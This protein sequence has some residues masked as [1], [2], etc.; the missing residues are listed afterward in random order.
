LN[1]ILIAF[2]GYGLKVIMGIVLN[3]ELARLFAEEL[4]VNELGFVYL[5]SAGVVFRVNGI[6]FVIDAGDLLEEEDIAV[7]ERPVIALYTHR[8]GDHFHAR[9]AMRLYELKGAVIIAND[10]V[11]EELEVFLPSTHLKMLAPLKGV[12]VGEA[13][14]YA[15]KANH[16]EP[17]NMYYIILKKMRIFH[18]D[19]S[20]YVNLSKLKANVAFLP[21]GAPSSDASP[22]DAAK[23]AR[24]LNVEYAIAMHGDDEQKNAFRKMLEASTMKVI[25]PREREFVRI[26]LS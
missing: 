1:N 26:R 9:V 8:H 20:G 25:V 16:I 13:A 6:T 4:D 2:K 5:G 24:D 14:I 10:K 22:T 7:L 11:Y 3:S 15:I 23:M 12:K 18:G 17:A 19:S 21:V